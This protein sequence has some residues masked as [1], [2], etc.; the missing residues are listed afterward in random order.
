MNGLLFWQYSPFS[1]V[2]E[3]V[4]TVV[5]GMAHIIGLV[6]SSP[7]YLGV[8]ITVSVALSSE[9]IKRYFHSCCRS[10]CYNFST[11][12]GNLIATICVVV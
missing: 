2:H 6:F 4:V 7:A 1:Y 12:I 8:L 10:R 11:V 9:V 5:V 3:C